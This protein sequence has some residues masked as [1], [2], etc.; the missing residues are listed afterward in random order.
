MS[1]YF[2]YFPKVEYS[3]EDRIVNLN[4]VTNVIF[5][6]IFNDKFKSD[7]SVFYF[8]SI[9]DGDKPE[10]I[11][12]KVYDSPERHWILL[13]FNDI[14]DPISD[15]PMD[16]R[17]FKSYLDDKYG[18]DGANNNPVIDGYDWSRANIKDYVIIDTVTDLQTETVTVE[19]FNVDANTYANTSTSSSTETLSDGNQITIVR[20]KRQDSYFDYEN[21][22]NEKKRV[23]KILKPEAVKAV[24]SEFRRLA[25]SS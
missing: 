15:W 8:Y 13:Q 5:R 22:L 7:S 2:N 1:K 20:T 3:L 18:A 24:E 12:Y 19:E 10:D 9:K 21:N 11:A 6:F 17:T 4:L 23:I 16:Q 14:V 25:E